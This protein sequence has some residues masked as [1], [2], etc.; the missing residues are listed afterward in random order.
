MRKFILAAAAAALLTPAMIST[1]SAETASVNVRIGSPGYH[2]GYNSGYRSG[3]RT[4]GQERVIVRNK[5]HCRTVVTHI[6]RDG[7]RIMKKVRKCD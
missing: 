7:V 5:P 6:R 4:Y 1:A 2:S 3:Y